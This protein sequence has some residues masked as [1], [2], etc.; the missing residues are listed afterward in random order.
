MAEATRQTLDA[1]HAFVINKSL[2][3]FTHSLLSTKQFP[4]EDII[5]PH[6]TMR[7]CQIISWGGEWGIVCS[8]TAL[9]L[10]HA[11]QFS[12]FRVAEVPMP[13]RQ[14]APTRRKSALY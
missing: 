9:R 2:H 13:P 8:N 3:F 7:Q 14:V 12:L 10:L 1:A 5:S 4:R 6:H 11:A